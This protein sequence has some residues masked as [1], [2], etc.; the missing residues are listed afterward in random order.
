MAY[1]PHTKQKDFV[2]ALNL[3]PVTKFIEAVFTKFNSSKGRKQICQ[4]N[5]NQKE[6]RISTLISDKIDC[7][8][9]KHY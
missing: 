9:N 5:T 3:K 1:F 2:V 8:A 6:A 4:A 7:K